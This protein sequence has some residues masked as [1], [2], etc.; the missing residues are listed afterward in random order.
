MFG[1]GASEVVVILVIA[2]IVLGPTKLPQ[3][4]RT[5]GK[6]LREF[7]RAANDF[8]NTI[9]DAAREEEERDRRAKLA[10]QNAQPPVEPIVPHGA[11]A[12]DESKPS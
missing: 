7:R 12:E 4:A 8:Q 6:G 10:S 1:L 5:V 3:L 2:L 9:E 11:P